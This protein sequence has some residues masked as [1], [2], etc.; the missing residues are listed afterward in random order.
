MLRALVLMARIRLSVEKIMMM[1]ERGIRHIL[2][3][4]GK[5]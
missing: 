4:E 3:R 5:K 1:R 2:G